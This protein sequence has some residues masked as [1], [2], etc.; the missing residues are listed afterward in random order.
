MTGMKAHGTCLGD[1]NASISIKR[2]KG[3]DPYNKKGITEKYVMKPPIKT[4]KRVHCTGNVAYD[5]G[6]QGIMKKAGPL[7]DAE[8]EGKVQSVGAPSAE[9]N[10]LKEDRKQGP[11][12]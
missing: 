3:T 5:T 4:T 7:R 6:T 12:S 9:L 1:N 11:S 2:K 8:E 10:S